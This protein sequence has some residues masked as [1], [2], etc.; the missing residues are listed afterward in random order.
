MATSTRLSLDDLDSLEQWARVLIEEGDD[1]GAGEQLL[2]LLQE[3]LE[4]GELIRRDEGGQLTVLVH[5][6][7]E[8]EQARRD[9][10]SYR[11]SVKDAR[12]ACERYRRENLEM[13]KQLDGFAALL[14]KVEALLSIARNRIEDGED[15][16]NVAAVA[17]GVF[18][19]EAAKPSLHLQRMAKKVGV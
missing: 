4:L 7:Q 17:D 13:R 1:D 5:V 9:V 3:R 16:G 8:L 6:Q 19:Q 10:S 2:M 15:P 11:V 14:K 12:E 18:K